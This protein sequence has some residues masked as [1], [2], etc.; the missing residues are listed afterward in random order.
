MN[1]LDHVSGKEVKSPETEMKASPV[2]TSIF[3]KKGARPKIC[4]QIYGRDLETARKFA[5]HGLITGT[6]TPIIARTFLYYFFLEKKF[7]LTEDWKPHGIKIGDQGDSISISEVLDISTEI[8]V[9][10]GPECTRTEED[11]FW[12]AISCAAVYR[13]A[14]SNV[15]GDY[16]Q[17]VW[18]TC[19]ASIAAN[20]PGSDRPT[21]TQPQNLTPFSSD[22][23]TPYLLSA[24]D[25]IMCRFPRHPMSRI[26]VG[27][28][29]WRWK[30]C[31]IL[32]TIQ[33]ISR[34]LGLNNNENLVAWCK[35]TGACNEFRRLAESEEDTDPEGYVPYTR[36][37]Q[38]SPMSVLSSTANPDIH[39]WAHTMGVLLHR[40]RSINAR[41]LA[42]SDHATIFECALFTVYALINSMHADFQICFVS[43]ESEYSV[44]DLNKKMRENLAKLSQVDDSAPPEFRQP[45]EKDRCSWWAWY[46]DQGGAAVAKKWAKAELRKITNVRRG[47]VGEWLST[48]KL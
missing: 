15:K 47:T 26:R 5:F 1:K 24:I 44:K 30:N 7:V 35:H 28:Q 19:M 36:G 32:F 46:N 29:M 33:Y 42:G 48:Y 10:D 21:I 39:L 25:M 14:H 31:D 8:T 45:R 9:K 22:V 40:D 2:P 6:L 4:L 34:Q 41:D 38:L 16:R 12:I 17:K 13:V 20:F 23:Q 3:L 43:A 18:K 27:T 37:M 11:D